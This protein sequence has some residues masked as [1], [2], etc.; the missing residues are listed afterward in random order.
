MHQTLCVRE[1]A[2]FGGESDP[3]FSGKE[4]TDM[5][6]FDAVGKAV[7]YMTSQFWSIVSVAKPSRI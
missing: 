1:K 7:I 4:W 5:T 3:H 2:V 6:E